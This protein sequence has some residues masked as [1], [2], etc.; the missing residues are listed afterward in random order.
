VTHDQATYR[1][2]D[3]GSGSCDPPHHSQAILLP[4]PILPAG[5]PE[6][7]DMLFPHLTNTLTRVSGSVI[8]GAQ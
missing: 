8:P 1:I 2:E 5:T 6:P 4:I 3:I 7:A